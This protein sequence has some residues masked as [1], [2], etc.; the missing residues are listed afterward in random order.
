MGGACEMGNYI[1]FYVNIKL[2]N[3]KNL[4]LVSS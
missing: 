4:N 2:E 3:L 1:V